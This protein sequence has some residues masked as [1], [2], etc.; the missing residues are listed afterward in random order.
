MRS[1][2]LAALALALSGCQAEP[3]LECSALYLDPAREGTARLVIKHYYWE[4]NCA[5]GCGGVDDEV[6]EEVVGPFPTCYELDLGAR[7]EQTNHHISV[8]VD[9]DGP[10][11]FEGNYSAV[12]A[13]LEHDGEGIDASTPR[14]DLFDGEPPDI[15]LRPYDGG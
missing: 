4:Q 12:V 6:E 2:A 8:V 10:D 7:Q 5:D 9:F 1:L 15:V 3:D 11:S 14:A 13:D